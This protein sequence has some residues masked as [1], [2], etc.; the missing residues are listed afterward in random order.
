MAKKIAAVLLLF[1]QWMIPVAAQGTCEV[2]YVLEA[3]KRWEY[4]TYDA[5]GKPESRIYQEV[6]SLAQQPEGGMEALI[7]NRATDKN[8]KALT[9]GT[10]RLICKEDVLKMDL[11]TS[12][13]PEVMQSLSNME[14]TVEGTEMLLPAAL[15][16][17]QELP[18]AYTNIKAGMQGVAIVNMTIASTN[19]KV[20]DQ[21]LLQT[22][23]G[24]F[25]CYRISY[26]LSIKTLI[27]K[28]Y[29]VVEWYAK[30]AG[31][32]RSETYDQKGKMEHS[33]ELVLLN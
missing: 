15:S 1:W 30:G 6:K 29:R 28:T 8:G 32:V 3:G 7:E 13:S 27:K 31:M 5:K 14:I 10:F 17:G 2:F 25:D 4:Q 16:K 26:D 21:E 18:D 19:R 24:N 11:M 20:E 22:P 9:Q 12:L 23:A 33:M